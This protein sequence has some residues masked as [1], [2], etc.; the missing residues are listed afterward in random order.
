METIKNKIA[1]LV[2]SAQTYN[3]IR[4]ALMTTRDRSYSINLIR[5][6][7]GEMKQALHYY[8]PTYSGQYD[9]ER[10][11]FKPNAMTGSPR[12]IE[13][14]SIV[15]QIEK[16]KEQSVVIVEDFIRNAGENNNTPPNPGEMV[17][18]NLLVRL[19]AV[20][21]PGITLILVESPGAE[22]HLP[23]TVASEI[24]RIPIPMPKYN[25]LEECMRSEVAAIAYKNVKKINAEQIKTWA[26]KFARE[27]CGL[28]LTAGRNEA[29]DALIDNVDLEAALK[30]MGQRKKDLLSREL[31]MT[32]L[33]SAREEVPIGLNNLFNYLK[34]HQH[35][36][37][38]PGKDRA[39]GILLIGPPGTG[40]SMLAKAIGNWLNFPVIEFRISS[41]MNSYL[42]ETERRF[43][44]AFAVFEAMAPVVIFIDEFEKVFSSNSSGGERDGGTMMR[45]M[46]RL[47]SWLN[48][49]NSPNFIVATANNIERMGE[50]GSTI[51]RKG[52]FDKSFFVDVPDL[53]AREKI[54]EKLLPE[55]LKKHKN[56]LAKLTEKFTGADIEAL[57]REAKAYS[58]AVKQD[59]EINYLIQEI[60]KNVSRVNLIHGQFEELRHWAVLHC[61]PA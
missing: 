42:G 44:S 24:I 40:K 47:L 20:K 28:T 51:T 21:S 43:E 48:D 6:L 60:R 50:I 16:L 7:A 9:F 18:R 8:S 26:S 3:N 52:R 14:G 25:E 46:G 37:C 32:I 61:E 55:G 19:M 53:E 29:R 34:I 13:P 23:C 41:L 33:E 57:I 4:V 49:S 27:L 11:A 59:L 2:K 35:R 58:Q 54:F 22:V 45:V 30:L 1:R 10:N 38:V 17:A 36:I 5:E 56:E 31:A 15:N 12:F 39:K